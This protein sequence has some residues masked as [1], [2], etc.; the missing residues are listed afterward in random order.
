MV[1]NE[2]RLA[3]LV[4][5]LRDLGLPELE[6]L[7]YV[8]LLTRGPLRAAEIATGLRFSRAM[9]YQQ[10]HHLCNRGFAFQ[11]LS[12]PTR[13]EAVP[14]GVVLRQFADQASAALERIE[15]TRKSW[16]PIVKSLS[17]SS[18]SCA[19]I[20]Q[21]RIIQG[22]RSIYR[23][24]EK[25]VRS[26]NRSIRM[27]STH[28]SHGALALNSGFAALVKER[29]KN[30]ISFR[31]IVNMSPNFA[32]TYG[33]LF[34]RHGAEFRLLPLRAIIRYII[35]DERVCLMWFASDLSSLMNAERDIAVWC[36]ARDFVQT[37]EAHFAALWERASEPNPAAYKK[38]IITA[39]N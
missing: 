27:V 25:L 34:A 9:G 30:G 31:A 19:S 22:R 35:G 26:S 12:R 16:E 6:A 36:D 39:A 23:A 24:R 21:F 13:F 37:Q 14:L 17:A 2:P 7:T 5:R 3:N 29:A 33:G 28:P 38:S 8:R 10:L 15:D 18:D 1:T 20:S 4:A 11:S 32:G